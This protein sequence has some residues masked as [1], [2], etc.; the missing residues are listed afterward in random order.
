[1]AL[2]R[3]ALAATLA[4]ALVACDTPVDTNGAVDCTVGG[5]GGQTLAMSVGDV[6][7]IS[8]PAHFA[9][10]RIEAAATPSRYLF[11]PANVTPRVDAVEKTL[12]M[13]LRASETGSGASAV[14]AASVSAPLRERFGRMAALRDA[15][16]DDRIRSFES[17]VD[18]VAVR[19]ARQG[20]RARGAAAA[21]A[22]EP[23]VVGSTKTIRVP[24]FDDN[25]DNDLCDNAIAVS[26]TVKA[27]GEHAV[28]LLDN[29]APANG[30]TD[31]EFTQIAAEFDTLIYE[32]DTEYFG[33]PTDL[34]VDQRIYILYT[35][36]VN[37][38]SEPNSGSYVGGF[39][40]SGDLLEAASCAQSNEGEIFYLL[41]ADPLGQFGNDFEKDLIRVSTRGT[42]AHEFQHMINLGM[43]IEAP[44]EAE[45]E[46]SWLN[47]GLSH[48]AE[49]L[50]GRRALGRS[51]MDELTWLEVWS[52]ESIF[53][54]FFYQNFARF[55][56]YLRNPQGS[57]PTSDLAAQQL[58]YRGAAWA[59][60]RH[61]AD[62]Y[63]G[64]QGSVAAFTRALVL[65]ADTGIANLESRTAAPFEEQIR[66]WLL[67]NWADDRGIPN[68]DPHYEYASW[69]MREA[70]DCFVSDN[71]TACEAAYPL[72]V[73]SLSSVPAG[74][75]SL[76]L[77]TGTGAYFLGTWSVT[78]P[79]VIVQL[80]GPTGQL[81]Q[82]TGGR[83]FVLRSD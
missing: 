34:D 83:M 31:L 61:L 68:L 16:I 42:I 35:P 66:G 52:D 10:L 82:G 27:V 36:E 32:V 78:T 58:S 7:T 54:G 39:F 13:S 77:L 6:A 72:K 12:A 40:F 73:T 5:T 21:V 47:E 37:K 76:S 62:H 71:A 64:V 44:F 14:L 57:S 46:T 22:A 81:V 49:E 80:T 23:P 41:T 1:M 67:A 63:N 50:V 9:C 70:M 2:P 3:T 43:K 60:L 65:S 56:S 19:A 26:T 11:V 53:L 38:L 69:R 25:T 24:N 45:N 15:R 33:V 51:D 18:L 59:L 55:E 29:A 48:F 8:D 4:A 79:S 17:S 30:L 20:R 28:I 74:G 75:S